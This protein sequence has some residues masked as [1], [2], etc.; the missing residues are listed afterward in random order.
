MCCATVAR[1]TCSLLI[2]LSRKPRAYNQQNQ[3][4][5]VL[6]Y[7]STGRFVHV[8]E[9]TIYEMHV[10]YVSMLKSARIYTTKK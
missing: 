6:C 9:G 4:T 8:L 10:L 5:G 1:P 2:D 7:S 3:L